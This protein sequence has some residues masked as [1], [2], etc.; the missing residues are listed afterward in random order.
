MPRRP[1]NPDINES[2]MTLRQVVRWLHRHQS[3]VKGC[4]VPASRVDGEWRFDRRTLEAWAQ[5]LSGEAAANHTGILKGA[6]R[7]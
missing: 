5:R 4:E 7:I 6:W 1:K 3:L 2:A